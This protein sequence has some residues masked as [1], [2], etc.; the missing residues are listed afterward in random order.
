MKQIYVV[1]N[2]FKIIIIEG[3]WNAWIK[4][5]KNTIGRLS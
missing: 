2:G 3:R 4:A 5:G 1:K